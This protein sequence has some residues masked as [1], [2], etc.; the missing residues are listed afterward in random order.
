[1]KAPILLSITCTGR[2]HGGSTKAH[3]ETL[4]L[5]LQHIGDLHASFFLPKRLNLPALQAVKFQAVQ[6]DSPPP[7]LLA[8]AHF[9]ERSCLM[10][11]NQIQYFV[12]DSA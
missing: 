8:E 1:M 11:K 12:T 3:L 6:A 2:E 4:I 7:P 9:A 10:I 5:H